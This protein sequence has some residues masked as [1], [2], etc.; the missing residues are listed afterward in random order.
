[1]LI[2]IQIRQNSDRAGHMKPKRTSAEYNLKVIQT[3]QNKVF[4]TIGNFFI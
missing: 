1:M 3:F 2:Y 4:T